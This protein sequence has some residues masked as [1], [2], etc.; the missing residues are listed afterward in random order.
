MLQGV[1]LDP[2]AAFKGLS[3]SPWAPAL[4]TTLLITPAAPAGL[5]APS[6]FLAITQGAEQRSVRHGVL[7]AQAHGAGV[8]IRVLYAAVGGQGKTPLGSWTAL[9]CWTCM[10]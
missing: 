10:V 5:W 2:H 1:Q 7:A 6:C 9:L 8:H 4:P 3:C